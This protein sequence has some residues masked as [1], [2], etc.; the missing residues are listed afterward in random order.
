MFL[1]YLFFIIVF[2]FSV[3]NVLIEANDIFVRRYI[4]KNRIQ[5]MTSFL[6]NFVI[7]ILV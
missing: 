4:F 6:L 5:V 7:M 1:V 3:V 2:F